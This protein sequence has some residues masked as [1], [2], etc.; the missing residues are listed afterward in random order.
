MQN[1]LHK[2]DKR[3]QEKDLWEEK[4]SEVLLGLTYWQEGRHVIFEAIYLVVRVSSV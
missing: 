3:V 1:F 2:E 4:E